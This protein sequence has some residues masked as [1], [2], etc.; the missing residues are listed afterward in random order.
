MRVAGVCLIV[1]GG[2]FWLRTHATAALCGSALVNALDTSDCQRVT[3][4]HTIGGLG[5]LAGAGLVIWG[6]VR[7]G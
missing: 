2:W 7:A 4:L 5:A 6:F 1:I 3:I